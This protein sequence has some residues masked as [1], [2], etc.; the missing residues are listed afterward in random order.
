MGTI[1]G[2]M[3][4]GAMLV[5]SGRAE[6][7]QTTT[8]DLA[9]LAQGTGGRA[10]NRSVTVTKEDGR[11]VV[12]LDSRPGDGGVL[13]D[14]LLLSEGTIDVDLK[15][16]NVAQQSFLGIAFHVVDWTALEAV[17]FRPFNFR[18]P[19]PERRARAVQYVAHP[20]HTWQRLRAERPGQFEQGLDPAPDP[21]GWFHAR[22]VVADGRV[23]VYVD[24]AAK[25]SL[26][27]GGLADAKSGGV[28]L[29]V[30]NGSD[31]AFAGLRV[32]ATAP[33]G[34]PPPSRQTV[35]QAASTGNLARLRALVDAD[36]KLVAA[37]GPSD[38][39]P[40]HAA[41]L[42][43]QSAAAALL[44]ER[45]ADPNA[46]A[47]HAGTPLDVADE[48]GQ[49]EMAAWLESRGASLTPLRFDVA[50][51]SPSIHRVTFPWGMRN[52]VVVLSSAEGAVVVDTGFSTRAVP[53]LKALAAGWST[54]GIRYVVNTHTHGD[55]VAGNAL[56]PS[57]GAVVTAAA[58]GG[59]SG[60]EAARD[61]EPLRGRSGRTLPAPWTLRVGGREIKLVH[62]PGLHSDAD[63]L[64]YFPSESVVAMGDLLLSESVP[65]TADLRGY[66]AFLDDVLDV[67]P[68]G[69]TFVSGHGRDL[70]AAGLRAY[71][72]DLVAMIDLVRTSLAAGRT[73]EQM[74]QDD[75]LA[76]YEARY[77]LL[78]FLTPDALIP[79]AVAALREGSLK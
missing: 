10:F 65:A 37:R 30:G 17:Y 61:P 56:A 48:A 62:R 27:V 55:H 71:R 14:G 24:G 43:G 63:L 42:Y 35:F 74:V 39:T 41:A 57:P 60:L 76:A 25:P 2:L 5:S 12:R 34:P 79:R 7:P 66:L 40:L 50:A 54:A 47:R 6:G 9:G 44:L 78:A 73:A 3:L 31:G 18:S 20:D 75:V 67:F 8:P 36:P 19:D 28:A 15:G 22:I 58:L 70:D 52:N 38:F 32:T 45:G 64:V 13:L 77:S 23:D 68:E 46:V 1:G 33:A 69:T 59:A 72:A 29:F 4:L 49:A 16:K 11:A 51:L 21:D 26:S 53:E